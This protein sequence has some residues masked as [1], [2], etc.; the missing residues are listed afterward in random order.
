MT[1]SMPMPIKSLL[2]KRTL[3]FLAVAYTVILTLSTL[4][5]TEYLPQPS[6]S[7]SD[8]IAHAAAFFLF[9]CIWFIASLGIAKKAAYNYLLVVIAS[10]SVIYGILI[11]VLQYT[12]T[13]YR[14]F[15][16]LDMLAN[17]GGVCLAIFLLVG[18]RKPLLSLKKKI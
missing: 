7:F 1:C 5:K 9:A 15:D 16:E 10:V 18:L 12:L 3:I 14:S 6:Y 17:T 13:T 11:E 8:K 2:D 4:V